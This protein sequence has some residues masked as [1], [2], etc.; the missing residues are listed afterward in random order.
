[1]ME[2]DIR[3]G[4][5]HLDRRAALGLTAA[6]AAM[7]ALPAHAATAQRRLL[8]PTVAADASRIYRKLRYRNDDG[9]VF[10]WIKGPYMAAIGGDLI[11]IY[12]IN[13]GSIQRIT[14]H[15]DGSFDL[16]DLEISFRVD[17]DSGKRLT[18]LRNP[19]TGETVPIG[20]RPIVPTRVRVS[21]TNEIEIPEVPGAP[22]FEHVHFPVLPFAIG[23][24]EIA[25][26]DRS[27]ARVTAPDGAISHLNEVS[28]LSAPRSTVL[29]A[30][31]NSVE[32][33][34]Q[35]N[36]VRSWPSWLKMGERPGTLNLF[37]NGGKVHSFQAL[38]S[39]WRE[40]LEEVY[41]EIAAD[42]IAALDRR[43]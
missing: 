11:P 28:T 18:Q 24:D 10:S 9:L 25:V 43:L 2:K 4:Q 41:P 19:I 42:P 22:R 13:L 36:D 12:A 15:A 8:D 27:H 3:D 16:I 35:S 17:V 5:M 39:D 14:H 23:A 26:R 6:A 32:T 38:P 34:V 1:M 7:M 30:S 20:G 29:D 33:R 21:A 40:M 31:V 37:G